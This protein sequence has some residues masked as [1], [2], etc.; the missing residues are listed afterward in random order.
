MAAVGGVVG[1]TT[2]RGILASVGAVLGVGGG[3]VAALGSDLD[4]LDAAGAIRVGTD[5]DAGV[6]P[7]DDA[8]LIEPGTDGAVPVGAVVWLGAPVDDS[9]GTRPDPSA[10]TLTNTTDESKT[11]R[12]G[13][14][15]A[16]RSW[17]GSVDAGSRLALHVV[18]STGDRLGTLR[19]PG[20][21]DPATQFTLGPG[22]TAY[23]SLRIDTTGNGARPGDDLSGTLGVQAVPAGVR[24]EN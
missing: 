22:A 11:V 10:V 2:R 7:G 9:S 12:V 14:R 23:A 19:V 13:Y 18:S 17:I 24:A 15:L 6:T 1:V 20:T 8:T 3:A 16:D 4:G 21:D 5:L